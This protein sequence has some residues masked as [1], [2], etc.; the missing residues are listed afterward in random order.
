M[1]IRDSVWLA[2]AL[3]G[4]P[5]QWSA[6]RLLLPSE[7]LTSTPATFRIL[8]M[9]G[10]R[11]SDQPVEGSMRLASAARGGAVVHA[12]LMHN[13]SLQGMMLGVRWAGRGPARNNRTEAPGGSGSLGVAPPF[14]CEHQLEQQVLAGDLERRYR[15]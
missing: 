7:H 14:F 5:R 15:L 13:V 12:L 8:A 9:D 3:R 6:P 10:G 11:T 1:C 2:N 4:D